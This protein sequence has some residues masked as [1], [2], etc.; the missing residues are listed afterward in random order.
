[1]QSGITIQNLKIQENKELLART[2]RASIHS[3]R[4]EPAVM[5]MGSYQLKIHN[6]ELLPHIKPTYTS[7]DISKLEG[8]LTKKEFLN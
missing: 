3:T 1:M 8:L 7:S 6:K 2:L 5:D 4:Y